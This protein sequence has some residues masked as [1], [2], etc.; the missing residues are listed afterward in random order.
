M[1]NTRQLA[2]YQLARQNLAEV[3]QLLARTPAF[4]DLHTQIK[5]AAA[6]VM[7]NIAEGSGSA[8][9][10]G[11]ARFLGHARASN[12]ELGAQLDALVALGHLGHD[13]PLIDRVDH[14]G[15]MLTRLMRRLE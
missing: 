10:R 13:H 7:L 2:V 8:T 9:P 14:C 12:S 6:S 15:R 3:A 11:F 1:T 5:R 4:G